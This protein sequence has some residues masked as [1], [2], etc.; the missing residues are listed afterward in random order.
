MRP[1]FG[2]AQPEGADPASCCKA[3]QETDGCA[4]WSLCTKADG[5]CGKAGECDAYVAAQRARGR[6]ANS[7]STPDAGGGGGEG[8]GEGEEGGQQQQQDEPQARSVYPVTRFG[9]FNEKLNT[10]T[11]YGRWPEH[12]C[13]L[14]SSAKAGAKRESAAGAAPRS[15]AG[16]ACRRA[17]PGARTGV[18]A[19]AQL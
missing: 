7:G 8:G 12:T 2:A 6:G 10:C 17:Q 9:S 15:A 3:C 4:A 14:Y 18:K 19:S 13:T 11:F 1:A 16:S 5:G